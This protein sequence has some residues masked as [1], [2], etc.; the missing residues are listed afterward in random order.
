[1]KLVIGYGSLAVGNVALF[2]ASHRPPCNT[3]LLLGPKL[4][5][6]VSVEFRDDFWQTARFRGRL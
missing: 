1:V 3:S 5:H 2:K 6:R 4:F